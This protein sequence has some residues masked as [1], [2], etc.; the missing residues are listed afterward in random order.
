MLGTSSQPAE[1]RTKRAILP[2]WL[3]YILGLV[4]ASLLYVAILTFRFFNYLD[5]VQSAF[6]AAEFMYLC[7]GFLFALVVLIL[8]WT[9]IALIGHLL[10]VGRST[11]L[12]YFIFAGALSFFFL[13]C[14]TTNP[15]PFDFG[16]TTRTQIVFAAIVHQ[17][18]YFLA[19]G[20]LFGASYCILGVPRANRKT[21]KNGI[22]VV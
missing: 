1:P 19:C 4:L 3:S 7:G 20:G 13:N 6:A 5:G 11:R 10:D 14:L 8:P 12:V 9:V 22:E 16:W 17:G 21:M 18:L 2:V 15:V